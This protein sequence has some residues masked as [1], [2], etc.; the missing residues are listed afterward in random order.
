[1]AGGIAFTLLIDFVFNKFHL[2]AHHFQTKATWKKTQTLTIYII[3]TILLLYPVLTNNF[4]VTNYVMG[5][6]PQ[7]YEFLAEQ[8]PDI[9][10][11]SL[12]IRS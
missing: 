8:P 10:I 12:N 4:P 9:R 1:M 5:K 11:A 2:S 7:L 3:L 6:V